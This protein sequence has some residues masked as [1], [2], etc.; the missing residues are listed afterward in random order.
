M[1]GYTKYRRPSRISVCLLAVGLFALSIVVGG[2]TSENPTAGAPA[3]TEAATAKPDP[4]GAYKVLKHWD[5]PCSGHGGFGEDVMALSQRQSDLVRVYNRWV[6][7]HDLDKS[8]CI[9]F[10][11]Y[12]TRKSF[13]VS[14]HPSQ[15]SDAELGTTPHALTYINNPNTGYQA[16]APPNG[17]EHPL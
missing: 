9:D 1:I 16:W 4:R 11:A 6:K 5:V 7:E 10:F 3:P 15:Y 14:E 12:S 17:K 2:C 13:E 8:Q